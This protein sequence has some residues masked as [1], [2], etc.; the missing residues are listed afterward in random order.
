MSMQNTSRR[1]FLRNTIALSAGLALP[2]ATKLMA[3]SSADKTKRKP[4]VLLILLDDQGSIDLNCYGAKDLH[5]PN[6][7]RLAKRG[8]RF[9]QFYVGAP[10][11]SPSRASLLTGRYPQRAEL[12]GNASSR[13]N[14]AG[15]PTRQI[16]LA[17]VLKKAGYVTG[18]IGKWHLGYTPET[19]PNAQGFDYSFGHMGGCIDNYS[20][21]FYWSG[22]NLHDL[23]RNGKEVWYEG[24]FLGDLMVK[25]CNSFIDKHKEEPF[26]LY[27]AIN[28]PHYPL[29]GKKKFREMYADMKEP[30]K[31]YAAFLST[32]D[33]LIGQVIEKIN[34]LGLRKD[35]MIIYLSDHGHS[36]EERAN[37]GGGDSGPYRGHKFTLWEG[38][39]RV[40][41]IVSW[42][43][44]FPENA[45]RDQMTVS[46]DYYPTIAHY[47]GAPI[48]HKIDGKDISALI[49]SEKAV[50]PHKVFF[51]DRGKNGHWAVRE[52]DW[53]LVKNGPP[54]KDRGLDLPA[55]ETFLSNL[56]EDVTETKNIAD[57]YPEIVARLTKLHE[58]WLLE[59]SQQ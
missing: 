30:R 59:A 44:H 48:E 50:S 27:W 38:G 16:T 23:W 3:R 8:T 57:Q 54:T 53:K 47:C 58:K 51:W 37:Y 40:P 36:V 39:I 15:M 42:P 49:T 14:H 6:L 11:C 10:V 26:F 25:E 29:Q 18:H 1:D 31:S 17:E 46:I 33:E 12:V 24:Q 55:A 4:N 7:D 43:G 2:D 9:T 56:A 5:T 20:H 22:P 45:V 19:M 34:T 32:A 21:F 13:R 28:M 41:S 35:T 52:G